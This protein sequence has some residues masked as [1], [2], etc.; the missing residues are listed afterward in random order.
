MTYGIKYPFLDDDFYGDYV[1]LTRTP[2]EEVKS[3]LTHLILTRKGSRF[4]LPDFGT[5]LYT[6][7][8]EQKDNITLTSIEEDIII[9]CKKY[10]PNAN[11][12]NIIFT[13]DETNEFSLKIRIEYSISLNGT[14][15]NDFINISL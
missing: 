10:I 1:K 15:T 6:F 11:I 9:N 5:N 4:M 3:N 2:E 8:F 12:K 14:I 13:E 7:L